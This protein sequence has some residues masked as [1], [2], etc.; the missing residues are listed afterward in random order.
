MNGLP[1]PRLMVTE[2]EVVHDEPFTLPEG[3]YL[4]NILDVTCITR[5]TTLRV[6]LEE[7]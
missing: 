1:R 2:V 4:A 6:L 3:W 7:V 5:G